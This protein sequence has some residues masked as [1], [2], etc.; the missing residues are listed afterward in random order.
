MRNSNGI[1]NWHEEVCSVFHFIWA[2]HDPPIEIE[3]SSIEMC[4]DSIMRVHHDRPWHKGFKNGQIP[5]R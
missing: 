4:V 2:K 5:M 3:R 1:G